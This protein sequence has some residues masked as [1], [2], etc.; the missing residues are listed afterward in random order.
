[1]GEGI[2]TQKARFR[3]AKHDTDSGLTRNQRGPVLDFERKHLDDEVE[4][5]SIVDKNGWI[6]YSDTGDISQ[7]LVHP[8]I[9]RGCVITHNHPSHLN[10]DKGSLFARVGTPFSARDIRLAASRNASEV[11]VTS[12]DYVYSLRPGKDG[13][14]QHLELLTHTN[15]IPAARRH[16]G[17][18]RTEKPSDWVIGEEHYRQLPSKRDAPEIGTH[19]WAQWNSRTQAA[20]T[21]QNVK[22]WLNSLE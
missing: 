11:R 2:Y 3:D 13:R 22:K 6:H 1:M 15:D 10:G 16:T 5:V 18:E 4:T 17:L 20:I 14:P 19:E 21:H 12:G 8:G 9:G 7:A